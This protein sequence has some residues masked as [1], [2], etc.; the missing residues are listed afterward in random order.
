MLWSTRTLLRD[1][2]LTRSEG[3]YCGV[4]IVGLPCTAPWTAA[5]SRCWSQDVRQSVLAL[6]SSGTDISCS[7]LTSSV[8]WENNK[9]CLSQCRDVNIFLLRKE[10]THSHYV[11]YMKYLAKGLALAVSNWFKNKDFCLFRVGCEG[12]ILP[13]SSNL[14]GPQS[15]LQVCICTQLYMQPWK[16]ICI[17][18]LYLCRIPV[19]YLNRRSNFLNI[20][21]LCYKLCC[22]N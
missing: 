10:R 5:L 7:D 20:I 6:V 17:K 9:L 13:D 11:A 18:N 16:K 19:N 4:P 12:K 8:L 15:I 21:P 1:G 14:I 2:L 22:E 3:I